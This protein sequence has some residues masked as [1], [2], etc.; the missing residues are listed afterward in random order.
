VGRRCQSGRVATTDFTQITS[1]VGVKGIM[2]KPPQAEKNCECRG[3]DPGRCLVG[4]TL[5]QQRAECVS[6]QN[7]M[8]ENNVIQKRRFR[9]VKRTD[10]GDRGD[11]L[12]I[13]EE[14]GE[15]VII[16]EYCGE[17]ISREEAARRRREFRR[18]HTYLCGFAG[19]WVL[20]GRSVGSEARYI[21]S[22]HRPNC[23]L[24]TWWVGT[25]PHMVVRTLRR[26]AAGEEILVDYGYSHVTGERERCLCGEKNCSGWIGKRKPGDKPP[27]DPSIYNEPATVQKTP[28]TGSVPASWFAHNRQQN[29]SVLPDPCCLLLFILRCILAR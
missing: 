10:C 15:D 22:S 19:G 25:T 14:V 20:D 4:C 7:V 17:V 9:D 28:R 12:R 8:C 1:N 24:E 16:L 29:L 2:I 21:N 13:V 3:G 23:V 5:R 18:E 6:C 27:E 26:L 11:G